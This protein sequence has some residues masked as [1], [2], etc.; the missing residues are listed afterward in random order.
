[1]DT[2][3]TSWRFASTTKLFPGP[4]I[5]STGRIERVP[6]A[7]A[8]MQ[9]EQLGQTL[10]YTWPGSDPAAQPIIVMAHQD[11]V[12]VTPGTE[13]DWKYQPCAGTIAEGAVGERA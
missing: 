10:V 8:A 3:P 11:V 1:M 2:A 4:K 7:S 13:Q 5:R 12:P 6:K 9:Q